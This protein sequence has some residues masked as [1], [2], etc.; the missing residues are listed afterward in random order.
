[1]SWQINCQHSSLSSWLGS[2][3]CQH[4]EVTACCLCPRTKA[5]FW[6]VH[7]HSESKSEHCSF[8]ATIYKTVCPMLSFCCMFCLSVCNVG[9]LW[10]NGW[11]DQG[12][13]W[14]AGRPQPW[15]HYVRWGPSSSPSKG[16]SPQFSA[17]ICCGQM[18]GWIEMPLGRKVGLGPSDI[19]L[20]RD[21]APSP[22]RAQSFIFWPMS[23]VARWLNGSRCH[24]VWR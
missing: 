23:I 12:E 10:P 7:L 4:W 2:D 22:K 21:S 9:V 11:M 18:A 6:C 17:H 24:L 15:P 8:W 20:V 16:H 1:M 5:S 13:T 3:I 19:L 14:H